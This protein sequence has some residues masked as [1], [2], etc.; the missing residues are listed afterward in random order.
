MTSL[1]TRQQ[2][3]L[4]DLRWH[5]PPFQ[6][7]CFVTPDGD[8]I[9]SASA[10]GE[11]IT[12]RSAAALRLKLRAH[13]DQHPDLHHHPP[14]RGMAKSFSNGVIHRGAIC[15]QLMGGSDDCT[16]ARPRLVGERNPAAAGRGSRC[17]RS[18]SS[19]GTRRVYARLPA[20][21]PAGEQQGEGQVMRRS[22]RSLP[23]RQC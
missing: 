21:T 14:N 7:G 12:A 13:Y 2:H 16:E 20:Q 11:I 5:W 3:D 4:D 6:I 9:W 19:A 1:S 23:W 15:A 8:E 22:S 10:G 18:D 17:G